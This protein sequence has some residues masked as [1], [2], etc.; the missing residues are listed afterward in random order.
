M[1]AWNTTPPSTRPDRQHATCVVHAHCISQVARFT[2]P[3]K[4]DRCSRKPDFPLGLF[5]S[6][7]KFDRILSGFNGFHENRIKKPIIT[8]F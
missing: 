1:E 7:T 6:S 8:G 4:T 3:T 2:K 5:S